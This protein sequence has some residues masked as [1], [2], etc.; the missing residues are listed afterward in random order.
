MP[1]CIFEDFFEQLN[2]NNHLEVLKKYLEN[3]WITINKQGHKGLAMTPRAKMK[4]MTTPPVKP[5]G[6]EDD[7]EYHL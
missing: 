6:D 7:D 5:N 2:G 4:I 3:G 1:H